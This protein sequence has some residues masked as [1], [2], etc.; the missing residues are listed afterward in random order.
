MRSRSRRALALILALFAAP[1]T[2]AE[3]L[4]RHVWSPE[5]AEAGG[6]SALW[7]GPDGA[8]MVVLSDRGGWVRGRLERG[9]DG[10]VVD[11]R[12]ADRG[13]LQRSTGGP[14]RGREKDAESIARVGDAFF[15][16]FEGMSRVMRYPTINAKPEWIPQYESFAT[17]PDNR[18]L[19]A[20]AADAEGRLYAVPEWPPGRRETFPVFRFADRRWSTPFNLSVE[21]SYM[22]TG[23]DFGPGGRLYVLERKLTISG[24]RSRV[25]SFAP[26][27]TDAR[28]ELETRGGVHDNLE[29]IAIWRDAAGRLRATMVSDDNQLPW[30]QTTEFVDYVLD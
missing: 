9:P 30:L 5:I 15:V 8:E 14:L 6:Y 26:D 2:G 19:E 10:A 11:V 13:M 7:L 20:L 23:A 1:A 4:G 16:S 12:I 27:G 3:L 21:D 18:G 29:G 25:R 22:V 24:F 28:V 17:L